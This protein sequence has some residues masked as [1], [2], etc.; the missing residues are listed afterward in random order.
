MTGWRKSY[1]DAGHRVVV[2]A[3]TGLGA[4]ADELSPA[5]DLSRHITDVVAGIEAAGF[6][7]FVLAGHSYGGMVVTGVATRLGARIDAL[8]YIDAFLPRDGQSLWDI[9]GEFEHRHYI[10]GQRDTPGLVAPLPGLEAPRLGRH[11]LL[12]LLEPVRFTG[13]EEKVGR[14]VYVFAESWSP[15]P[16]MGFHDSVAADPAWEVH[17]ADAGHDVMAD[18]PEQLLALM[19]A[20]AR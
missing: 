18:Q 13:E 7:R 9:S 3:L 19:L 10:D 1:D 6:D 15:T 11:P 5:I 14:R 16:F 8:V 4:R 17:R 2:A 20:Q 12:T